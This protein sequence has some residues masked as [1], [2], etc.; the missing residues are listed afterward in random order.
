MLSG[1]TFVHGQSRWRQPALSV[2]ILA[3]ALSACAHTIDVPPAGSAALYVDC[4]VSVYSIDNQSTAG[5][6]GTSCQTLFLGEGEHVLGFTVKKQTYSYSL[7][8]FSSARKP[9]LELACYSTIQVEAGESYE[10]AWVIGERSSPDKPG[11]DA[12]IESKSSGSEVGLTLC[13]NGTAEKPLVSCSITKGFPKPTLSLVPTYPTHEYVN[14]VSGE[15]RFVARVMRDG[16]VHSVRILETRP[17]GFG[18]RSALELIPL[19]WRFDPTDLRKLDD[20]E[21]KGVCQFRHP[22]KV[23]PG[24]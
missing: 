8:Y 11:F 17:E 24:N 10:V 18:G 2:A 15:I 13:D 7:G 16:S 5:R 9:V 23:H 12:W 21:F 14:G 20:H 3:A 1:F 4:S 19:F 6:S 22:A